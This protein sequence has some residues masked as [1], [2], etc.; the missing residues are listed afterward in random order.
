MSFYPVSFCSKP[1]FLLTIIQLNVITPTVILL[2]FI[3]L[4]VIT[5]T[6]IIPNAIILN[7][8]APTSVNRKLWSPILKK[9]S[10]LKG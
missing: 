6:V 7:V 3:P 4:S 10:G 9:L 5:L 1:L 2:S 8:V